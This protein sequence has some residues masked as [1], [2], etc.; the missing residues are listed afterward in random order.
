M[1]RRRGL[2]AR[3]AARHSPGRISTFF[4]VARSPL[5]SSAARLS[6]IE[7]DLLGTTRH[8]GVG[9]LAQLPDLGVGEGRLRRAAPAEQIHLATRLSRSASSA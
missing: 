5:F 1:I 7:R 6:G 2:P 4:A 3:R 8:V 9:Q